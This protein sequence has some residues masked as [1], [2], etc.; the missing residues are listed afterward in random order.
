MTR[1]AI[2]YGI[3]FLVPL[4]IAL[5]LQKKWLRYYLIMLAAFVIDLDHLFAT[6]IFDANRCSINTHV[7]HSYY[8]MVVYLILLIPKRT[9]WFGIGLIIHICADWIDC[10]LLNL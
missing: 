1:F 5:S 9:R 2:H 3:H 10:A 6:P 8:A 4:V 7:L